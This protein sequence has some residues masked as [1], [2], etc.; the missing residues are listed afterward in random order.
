M[1]APL[2]RFPSDRHRPDASS[3]VP[4]DGTAAPGGAASVGAA[5]PPRAF[6][7]LTLSA[8]AV[9]LV[10]AAVVALDWQRRGEPWFLSVDGWP[11]AQDFIAYRVAGLLA[12]DGHA[13]QAYRPDVFSDVLARIMGGR[14]DH[15]LGWPYPPIFILYVTPLALLPYAWAWTMWLVVTAGLLLALL[16]ATPGL[17]RYAMVVFAAPASFACFL[18]GQNGFLSAALLTG[19]L[20]LVDRR[21]RLSGVCLGLLTFKPHFGLV[22]PL[23]LLA[24]RRWDVIGSAMATSLALVVASVM[25]YGAGIWPDFAVSAFGATREW[26]RPEV[27]L[28]TM[29]TAYAV[30]AM[31]LEPRIAGLLHLL[32]AVAALGVALRVWLSH[33]DLATRAAAAI[34]ST[35]LVTPYAHHHDLVLL[36]VAGALLLGSAQADQWVREAPLVVLALLLPALTLFAWPGIQAMGPVAAIM[37]LAIASRR[38]PSC[39]AHAGPP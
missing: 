35:I 6:A 31:R 10:Y 5:P 34:A 32:V 28:S 3:P 1:P 22:L 33:A 19:S 13:A 39:Q 24:T 8:F 12:V 21:P 7:A 11:L 17:R 16:L 29:Q 38:P 9:L 25:A 18:K 27:G 23:L 37:L 15:W 36:A 30:G 2:G 4:D 20:V 14:V 26:M